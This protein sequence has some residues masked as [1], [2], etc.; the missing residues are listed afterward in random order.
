MG[1][2]VGV[3]FHGNEE[4]GFGCGYAALCLPSLNTEH[5]EP[6]IRRLT[7]GAQSVSVASVLT[8]F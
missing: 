5:T 3:C 4:S 6:R 2:K 8:S 1:A 7:D